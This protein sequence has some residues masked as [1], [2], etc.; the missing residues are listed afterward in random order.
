MI[1]S[2]AEIVRSYR[3]AADPKKQIKVLAEL[4]ACSVKEIRQV[5]GGVPLDTPEVLSWIEGYIQ[6]GMESLHGGA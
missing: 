2:P 5:L 6:E 3:M 1:D 4:N